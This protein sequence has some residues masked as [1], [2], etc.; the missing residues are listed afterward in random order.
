MKTDC[1]KAKRM[2]RWFGYAV[3]GMMVAIV[4][5]DAA[6]LWLGMGKHQAAWVSLQATIP[7]TLAGHQSLALLDC[8]V[9]S[10]IFLYGLYR[11]LRLMHLYQ[12]GEFFGLDAIRHLRA[13]ALSLLA[14]TL[15]GCLL[16]AL[17]TAMARLAGLSHAASVSIDLDAS[18]VWMILISFVFFVIAWILG[19]A[20]QIAEDNQSII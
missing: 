5:V 17:E 10:A 7:N 18:D 3:A 19:E 6:L 11:L 4:L 9:I 15:A 13:F 14:G 16:P 8:I 12:Q 1:D 20:R 2:A